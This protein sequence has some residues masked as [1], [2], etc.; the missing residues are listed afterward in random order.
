MNNFLSHKRAT[1]NTLTGIPMQPLFKQEIKSI[2]DKKKLQDP[3]Y[4]ENNSSNS[5]HR[6][7]FS[8]LSQKAAFEPSPNPT[9]PLKTQKESEFLG[10][11]NA[12]STYFDEIQK[13][14][15]DFPPCEFD[16][17]KEQLDKILEE[18]SI[19]NQDIKELQQEYK[20]MF[21]ILEEQKHNKD[22]LDKSIQSLKV[23]N[24]RLELDITQANMMLNSVKNSS[25]NGFI[26][27]G[28][29]VYQPS[30]VPIKYKPISNRMHRD[31]TYKR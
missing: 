10:L 1:S 19:I 24:E 31:N 13:N 22:S 26:K 7:S 4:P 17:L 30:P 5:F 12:A 28:T 20:E 2:R 8:T 27:D 14:P 9:P 29:G 18:N 21:D 23:Y 11:L 6:R 25:V 15:I 16:N 3:D